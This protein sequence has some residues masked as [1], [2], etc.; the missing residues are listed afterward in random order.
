MTSLLDSNA[1]QQSAFT[2]FVGIHARL[3]FYSIRSLR[4][5][6]RRGVIPSIVLPGGRKRVFH[7]PSVETALRR[8]QTGGES[9]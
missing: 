2:D 4:D 7:W 9:S 1:S 3:P 8:Y 5:L 6:V